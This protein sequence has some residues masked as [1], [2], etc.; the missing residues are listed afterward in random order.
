MDSEEHQNGKEM[1][2][3]FF[4]STKIVFKLNTNSDDVFSIA[5]V[6]QHSYQI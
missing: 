5:S 6:R 1:L 4:L 3:L 2:I